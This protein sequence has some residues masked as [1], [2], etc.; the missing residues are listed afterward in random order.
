MSS[1]SHN[2]DSRGLCSAAE[3]GTVSSRSARRPG[4]RVIAILMLVLGQV[5]LSIPASADR[6]GRSGD[7]QQH[8]WP[9]WRPGETRA[10]TRLTSERRLSDSDS[11]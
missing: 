11:G 4:V 2:T 3:A 1:D 8:V 6:Q 10:T 9:D 5:A 7:R